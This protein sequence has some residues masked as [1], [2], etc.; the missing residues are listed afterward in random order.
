PAA[1]DQLTNALSSLAARSSALSDSHSRTVIPPCTLSSTLLP[2]LLASPLLFTLSRLQAT[3]DCLDIEGLATLL[4]ADERTEVDITAPSPNPSPLGAQPALEEWETWMGEHL[5]LLQPASSASST[6]DR[7]L[8]F[9]TH[10]RCEQPHAAILAYL[11][12]ATFKDCSL[13]VR[14][15]LP[16]PSFSASPSAS[17]SASSDSSPPPPIPPTVKAIDLDPKPLNRLGKYWRM[18][19]EIVSGWGEMLD[20]LE[21]EERASV[22]RC[23][24]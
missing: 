11:L 14:I 18:D 3:L 4:A 23:E 17:P 2:I 8:A 12:S 10:L 15:P 1:L 22:R 16:S 9:E 5:P 19:R 24:E 20:G 7:P 6:T 13:I 21:E